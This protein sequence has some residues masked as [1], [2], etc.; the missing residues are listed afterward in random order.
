[1]LQVCHSSHRSFGPCWSPLLLLL[2]LFVPAASPPALRSSSLFSPLPHTCQMGKSSV[3]A[4]RPCGTLKQ[5]HSSD[6][7]QPIR[8][9]DTAPKLGLPSALGGLRSFCLPPPPLRSPSVRPTLPRIVSLHSSVSCM[10][11]DALHPSH[12]CARTCVLVCVVLLSFPR[13]TTRTHRLR[14]PPHAVPQLSPRPAV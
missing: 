6:P 10:L 8:C 12:F 14:H 9:R 3:Q 7:I 1:M 13:P 4:A 11:V 5:G 2:L